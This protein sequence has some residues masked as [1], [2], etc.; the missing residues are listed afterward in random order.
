MTANSFTS[1]SLDPPT[2]LVSLVEGRT[3]R[4]IRASGQFTVNV[5][6]EGA[7]HASAHFAGKPSDAWS[8]HY[9]Q[10]DGFVGLTDVMARFACTVQR[11]IAVHDHTLLISQVQTCDVVDTEPL[12][13]YG[14]RYR[15]LAAA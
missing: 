8:P 14:S 3:L 12:V 4:A 13:F 10:T 2:I 11:S 9:T 7:E 1:V 5:L 6:G 15:R